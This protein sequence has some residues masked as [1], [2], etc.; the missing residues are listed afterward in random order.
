MR[1]IGIHCGRQ[2]IRGLACSSGGRVLNA[3]RIAAEAEDGV[4][5]RMQNIR[6]VINM[7]AQENTDVRAVGIVCPGRIDPHSG[8]ISR[9]ALPGFLGTDLRDVAKGLLDVPVYAENST[10]AAL[11]GEHWLGA[12]RD[13][14]KTV[15]LEL[16]TEP[17]AAVFDRQRLR[18]VYYADEWGIERAGLSLPAFSRALEEALGRSACL[19]EYE[20]CFRRGDPRVVGVLRRFSADLAELV[21]AAVRREKPRRILF[22]GDLTVWFRSF[23][24]FLEQEL[25]TRCLSPVI[26]TGR[27]GMNAGCLGAVRLCLDR[28]PARKE[29][30]PEHAAAWK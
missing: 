16:D 26:E 30:S 9:T 2:E 17:Q 24:P 5:S 20:D 13:G 6:S 19:E 3:A 18:G 11:L 7:L 15:L 1:I 4:L 10:A 22:G 25:R 14:K 27:L 8:L 21:E 12:A 28:L 23:L 29:P